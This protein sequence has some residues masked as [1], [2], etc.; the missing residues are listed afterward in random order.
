MGLPFW[1]DASEDPGSPDGVSHDW[2]TAAGRLDPERAAESLSVLA[3]PVR[4]TVLATLHRRGEL[5]YT[6]LK[7]ATGVEDRGRFNYHLRELDDFLERTDGR[8]ALSDRGERVVE[9]V[10]T[11]DA[12]GGGV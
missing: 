1:P 6:D 7:D 9:R 4:L 11:R 5:T 2:S 12:L 10:L 8:Y 3:N